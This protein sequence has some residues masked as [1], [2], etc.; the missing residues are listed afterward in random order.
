MHTPSP[1]DMEQLRLF[2][3]E[4]CDLAGELI[5]GYYRQPL[6]VDIKEDASPVT[7]ADREVERAIRALIRQR[8]PEHGIIG[9]EF[10]PIQPEAP[11]QWIIDPIDGTKSFLIGRPIFGTLLSLA[12]EKTPI[13][14]IIDQPILGERWIG[15]CHTPTWLNHEEIHVRACPT[16]E[17]ATLCTTSPNLFDPKERPCFEAI[18]TACRYTVYGGDCYSYGLLARGGVDAIVETDLKP[19][20]FCAIAPVIE[21][22]GGI[23]TDW[24]GKALKQNSTGQVLACGDHALHAAIL[25]MLAE[26]AA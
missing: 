12:H 25:P 16:I 10:E 9:E 13:L 14:G 21:G 23:I 24:H 22:A 19:H 1:Q 17:K 6:D 8:F 3:E 2:A 20:D 4:A 11:L 18:R 26:A 5:R 15:T 7:R